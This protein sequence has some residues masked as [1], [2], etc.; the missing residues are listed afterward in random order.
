MAKIDDLKFQTFIR[1]FV[2]F[3]HWNLWNTSN[4]CCTPSIFNIMLMLTSINCWNNTI[5]VLLK[6]L[7]KYWQKSPATIDPLPIK[8]SDSHKTVHQYLCVN[9]PNN[10][11]SNGKIFKPEFKKITETKSIQVPVSTTYL[12]SNVKI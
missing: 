8:A 3:F 12:I 11:L 9:S 5:N 2:L 1:V 4:K 6:L 7:S 10:I